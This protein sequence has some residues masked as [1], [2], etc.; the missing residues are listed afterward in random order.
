[1]VGPEFYF[2]LGD[3]V[4]VTYAAIAHFEVQHQAILLINQHLSFGLSLGSRTLLRFQGSALGPST[5]VLP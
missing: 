5:G 4:V 1:M 2:T 3:S